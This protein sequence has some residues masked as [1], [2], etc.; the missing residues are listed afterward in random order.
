MSSIEA[1][2]SDHEG[3][4][5]MKRSKQPNLTRSKRNIL[6]LPKLLK[7]VRQGQTTIPFTDSLRVKTDSCIASSTRGEQKREWLLKRVY[8]KLARMH[9]IYLKQPVDSWCREMV[10]R[11]S[12]LTSLKSKLEQWPFSRETRI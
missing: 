12:I 5:E 7:L 1:C 8:W 2:T 4:K 10:T 6:L 11:S 3:S 9:R